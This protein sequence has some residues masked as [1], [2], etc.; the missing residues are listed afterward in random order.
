MLKKATTALVLCVALL[1]GSAG[2]AAAGEWNPKRGYIHG[3][4]E[5]GA[6]PAR[7][8]CAYSGLDDPDVG[9][10]GFWAMSPA[11]GRVQSPGQLVAIAGSGAAGIPGQACRGNAVHG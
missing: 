9:D 10:D 8:E 5:S 6:H 4:D 3:P 1:V 2:V 7:S 11:K